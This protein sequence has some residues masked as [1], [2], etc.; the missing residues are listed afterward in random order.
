MQLWQRESDSKTCAGGL[1]G[2]TGAAPTLARPGVYM[3]LPS[4]HQEVRLG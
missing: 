4:A 1:L 2:T 3:G